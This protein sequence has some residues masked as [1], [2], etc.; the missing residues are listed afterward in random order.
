MAVEVAARDSEGGTDESPPVETEAPGDATRSG[1]DVGGDDVVGDG[2]GD[3]G[4]DGRGDGAEPA[5]SS[6]PLTAVGWWR[7]AGRLP[8]KLHTSEIDGFLFG[9]AYAPGS[10]FEAVLAV[11]RRA[12]AYSLLWGLAHRQWQPARARSQTVVTFELDGHACKPPLWL[13]HAV[14]VAC[15]LSGGG[16]RF[17]YPSVRRLTMRAAGGDGATLLLRLVPS[18]EAEPFLHCSSAGIYGELHLNARRVAAIRPAWDALGFRRS[19][20]FGRSGAACARFT[21]AAGVLCDVREAFGA[22]V[23]A[24]M[25]HSATPWKPVRYTGQPGGAYEHR[26]EVYFDQGIFCVLCLTYALAAN[27]TLLAI[28][29]LDEMP[30]PLLSGPSLRS[31]L[32]HGPVT[33]Q[34]NDRWVDRCERRCV[35]A[36]A[37]VFFDAAHSCRSPH[38]CPA[39][40]EDYRA[41]CPTN[42][43]RQYRKPIVRPKMIRD[44]S[45]HMAASWHPRYEILETLWGPCLYHE[46]NR[47]IW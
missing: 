22:I 4:G 43:T 47:S 16:A 23:R 38:F 28:A 27:A 5:Q 40:E 8:A 37:Y 31:A 20:V 44:L 1:G 36:G 3:V 6:A 18:G 14:R 41:S 39:S 33:A 21:S 45:V 25:G 32:L 35:L 26:A 15:E 34:V 30:S 42:A 24:E 11:H 19:V 29:D 46:D 2:H 13:T 17:P 10:G 12:T 9:C 7:C